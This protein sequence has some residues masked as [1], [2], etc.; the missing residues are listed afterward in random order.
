MFNLNCILPM[1]RRSGLSVLLLFAASCAPTPPDL[2]R[3]AA[4]QDE[5]PEPIAITVFTDKVELF[6]EYPRLRP[7]LEARFLAHVT[8]LE[9]GNPVRSGK[10]RLELLQDALVYKSLEA[11]KPTRDGLFIPIGTFTDPGHYE[12]RIIVTSEQA[13]ETIQLPTFVVHPDLASAQAAADADAGEDPKDAVPFLLEQQWKISMLMEKVERRSLTERLLVPCEV[14]AAPGKSAAVGAPLDGRL[15]PPSSGR[16]PRIGEAVKKGQLLGYLEP[17]LTHTD[18]AQ[19]AANQTGLDTIEL[20]LQVREYDLE[21]QVVAAD[22]ALQQSKAQL[23]FTEQALARIQALRGKDLGTV[24]ELELAE[25]NLAIARSESESATKQGEALSR[26][27]EQ[28]ASLRAKTTTSALGETPSDRH[29]YPLTAPISGEVVAVEFVEGEFIPSQ[30]AIY[31][32][33]DSDTVWINA[34]V[35]EFDLGELDGSSGALLNLAAY[36]DRE[37][38]V[39]GEMGG[40]LVHRGRVIQA[41]TRTLSRIYEIPNTDRAFLVGM[42]ADAYLETGHAKDAV[43]VGAS[44][45]VMD[46]GRPVA[47]VLVHGEMFQKR[48]LELGIRDGRFTEVLSGLNEGERVVTDGAYLVKL[49]SASPASFGAGHAH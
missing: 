3:A 4:A 2:V 9:D 40:S 14:E 34:H 6:M 35:S 48:F 13:E 45:V 28:V 25:R 23:Q 17:P 42:F 15:L 18:L 11:D 49:A 27:Q 26:A 46:G 21:G 12:A 5:E 44:S 31:R 20:E 16:L 47:F 1:D 30:G 38:D 7:G 39:L 10:L 37:F 22:Q 29:L 43:V 33:L 8:V 41:E 19:F 32:L 36:P 24:A